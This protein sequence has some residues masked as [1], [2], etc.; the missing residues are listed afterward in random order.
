MKAHIVLAHPESKSFNGQLANISNSKLEAAGW[1]VTYSDLYANNFDPREGPMHYQKLSNNERF[2]A[3][4][5]QRFHAE[6]ETTPHDV[7][8]ER[9]KM[10]QSDLLIVHFPLWWFGMPA[11]LKGWMDR[12]FIYG[13]VYRGQMRY[14]TGICKG[15]KMLAC[16]TTGASQDSCSFN[17]R[18]GDSRLHA[19]PI[20]FPF[21]YIGF[22]VLEPV[23]FHGVG[24]VAS[25]EGKEDGLSDIDRHINQWGD[26]LDSLENRKIT[27]FN[28]DSDFDESKRLVSNASVYSPFIS[29]QSN[30]PWD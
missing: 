20:L 12:V 4:T 7:A 16:I 23:I 1:E 24:G 21:R 9:D 6:S 25:I 10:L 29:H 11:I 18:E 17:G 8:I 30:T 14:D 22:D 19:W 2:H 3:Q 27:P 28:Q 26:M 13:S 5:E 15:K